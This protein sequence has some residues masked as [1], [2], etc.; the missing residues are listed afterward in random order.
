MD[1]AGWQGG[2]VMWEDCTHTS[3]YTLLALKLWLLYWNNKLDPFSGSAS[4]NSAGIKESV[5]VC[6]CV[7]VW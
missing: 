5:C 4:P 2:V 7:C 6:L 1:S 3:N